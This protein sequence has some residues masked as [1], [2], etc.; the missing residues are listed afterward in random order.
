VK[1]NMPEAPDYER[2]IQ[3]SE[4]GEYRLWA[5]SDAPCGGEF[6][7]DTIVVTVR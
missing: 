7:S 3:F 5:V 1:F 4:P 2:R 6:A